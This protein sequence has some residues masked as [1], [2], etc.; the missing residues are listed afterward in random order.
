MKNQNYY[1]LIQ[2]GSIFLVGAGIGWLIGLS[3]SPVLSG[4]L[5]SLLGI[6]AGVLTV[7]S[8]SK[9]TGA[10]RNIFDLDARPVAILII[11]I[12]LAAPLGILAR[13]H[14]IF[15]A[16]NKETNNNSSTIK[17]AYESEFRERIK[18]GALF[19]KKVQ[20]CDDLLSYS[21][22]DNDKLFIQYFKS[23]S[24][25]YRNELLEKIHDVDTLRLIV[26]ALCEK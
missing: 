15:S 26:R 13:S 8:K 1:V 18:S 16:Y 21:F 22:V 20:E 23:S 14:E 11:A 10:L 6:V 7:Y 25:P 12:S 3:A 2:Y 4:V 24:I 17:T 5:S 9:D 19:A